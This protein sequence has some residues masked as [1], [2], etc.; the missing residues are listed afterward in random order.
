MEGCLEEVA[1]SDEAAPCV[2]YF[3]SIVVNV[4]I[5]MVVLITFQT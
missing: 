3:L 5:Q 2:L 1:L 4:I